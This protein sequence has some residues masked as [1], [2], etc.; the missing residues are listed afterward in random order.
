MYEKIAI[1]LAK[2]S[3][4][5][6]HVAGYKGA[7][8]N[9]PQNIQVHSLFSFKRLS[10]GRILAPWK[11]YKLYLKVKPEDIIITSHDLLIVTC[12]YKILFGAKFIYDV[13]ENYYRNIAYTTTFPPII[14]NLIAGWVR[15]KEYL[16][17]PFIDHYFLAEKNYE[18]EFSFTKGK[19]TIL[20]N[21]ALRPV[22]STSPLVRKSDTKHLLYSG[23]ISENYGIFEAIHFA[24]KLHEM[25]SSIRLTIIGYSP[26]NEVFEKLA[27]AIKGHSFITLKGGNI[28]VPHQEIIAEI[29]KS[30]FGML[31]YL[32]N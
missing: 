12:I 13:Q 11:I 25:D 31:P 5:E 14:R 20:E 9:P 29:Q 2:E 30:D 19:S 16:T 24:K 3:G 18:K 22:P 28:L 15:L 8:R 10:M 4:F 32:F 26:K 17:R 1:S 21:K 23:T 27:K 7:V 6:V